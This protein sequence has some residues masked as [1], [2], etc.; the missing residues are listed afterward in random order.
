MFNQHYVINLKRR[1]ERLFTW[2]G[3]QDQMGFVFEDITV[4]EAVDGKA[5]RNK[6]AIAEYAVELGFDYWEPLLKGKKNIGHLADRGLTAGALSSLCL[7]REI[8]DKDGS[9]YTVLWEDDCV[10]TVPYTALKTIAVPRDADIVVFGK[11]FANA[12]MEEATALWNSREDRLVEG[13][14]F[15]HGCVGAGFLR[16]YA[17]NAE[18]A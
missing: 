10:L 6:R 17:V 1:P 15:Y 9:D 3:V 2:V 14:P 13:I 12:Q 11:M 16:C 4:F 5:F 8:A 7:L 18:G